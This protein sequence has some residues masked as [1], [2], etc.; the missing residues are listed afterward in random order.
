MWIKPKLQS[1]TVFKRF[2]SAFVVKACPTE[3]NLTILL[4]VI[5]LCHSCDYAIEPAQFNEWLTDM[6]LT[7]I[8]QIATV[9]NSYKRFTCKM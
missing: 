2:G 1:I 4:D 7:N 9:T 6:W 8:F 5:Y 3:K